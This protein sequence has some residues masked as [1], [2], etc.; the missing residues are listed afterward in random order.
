MWFCSALLE[1]LW[2]ESFKSQGETDSVGKVI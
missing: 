2:T 1:D